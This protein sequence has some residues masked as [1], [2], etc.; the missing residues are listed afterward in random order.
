VFTNSIG[1]TSSKIDEGVVASLE[2]FNIHDGNNFEREQ[3]YSA[4]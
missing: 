2:L 1:A 3:Q 4:T